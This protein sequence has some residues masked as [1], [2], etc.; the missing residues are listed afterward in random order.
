MAMP[1]PSTPSTARA[2]VVAADGEHHEPDDDGS[3]G[4]ERGSSCAPVVHER[5]EHE[6][7]ELD[8]EQEGG[9]SLANHL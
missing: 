4:Y 5:E 6:S 8:A 3:E 7:A 2:A 1:K 9:G